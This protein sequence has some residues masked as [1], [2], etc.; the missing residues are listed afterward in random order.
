MD[1]IVGLRKLHHHLQQRKQRT[2]KRQ[3]E[4]NVTAKKVEVHDQIPI[5]YPVQRCYQPLKDHKSY[6]QHPTFKC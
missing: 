4:E 6:S 3:H 2:L 5:A 1:V